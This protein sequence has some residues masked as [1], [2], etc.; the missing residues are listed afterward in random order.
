MNEGAQ[1]FNL[2]VSGD[3]MAVLLDCAL[4]AGDMEP[5]L[6][7]IEMGL[8]SLSVANTPGREQLKEWL[9]QA[10]DKGPLL[11]NA[12]LMEGLKPIPSENGY[13]E[14]A[15]D[16]FNSSFAVDEKTGAIDYR[17]RV[18]KAMVEEGQLLARATR[19]IEG[20]NGHDV[21]GKSIPVESPKQAR[22]V[23]GQNVRVE[24]ND[25][26]FF[27]HSRIKGRIRWAENTLSVDEV[28]RIPGSVGIETGHVNHPGAVLVEGDVL[29]GSRLEAEGDVEVMGTVEAA[30]IQA[31]GNLTVRRG[32][33]GVGSGGI[34]VGGS[35]HAKF[36]LEAEIEANEDIVIE[37]EIVQS[38]VKTRG[39]LTIFSGR[40]VGGMAM[41]LGGIVVGQAGSDGLVPTLLVAA[42]DYSLEEKLAKAKTGIPKFTK[43]LERIHKTVDP[44][45][46]REKALSP[47]QRE[48]ATELLARAAEMEVEIKKLR[49]EIDDLDVESRSRAKPHIL[50]RRRIYPETTLRIKNRSLNITEPVDGPVRAGISGAGVI[51][52]PAAKRSI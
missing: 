1:D 41:A 33:T 20:R 28:Y 15:Q 43:D 14:W 31:G 18:G 48:A 2:R 44:L 29:A 24:K 11:L 12:V 40:L 42:E 27:F 23:A 8:A 34:K 17:E 9:R 50:I 46:A 39:S 21:F 30:D 6:N 25:D 45:M 7:R 26:G 4:P 52:L 51:L 35:V 36:I 22:I 5:L 37:S 16:F 38:K 3:C 19:P 32:I 47:K 13:V 49:S 10:S